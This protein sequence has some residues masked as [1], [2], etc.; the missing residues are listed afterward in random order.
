M[1]VKADTS[2]GFR[3]RIP[4][5]V[6][7]VSPGRQ[8]LR[9]DGKLDDGVLSQ[10]L[11][12]AVLTM[13]RL[14]NVVSSL[15]QEGVLIDFGRA[16]QIFDGSTPTTQSELETLRFAREYQH[17]HETQRSELAPLTTDSICALHGSIYAGQNDEFGPGRLKVA[18]NGV[19]PMPG[20]WTFVA[21]PPERTRQELDA[22]CAWLAAYQYKGEPVSVAAMFF[23][24]FQG[25]HPFHDGN[26]RIGRLLNAHVLKWLGF[27]NIGLVPLDA[28][29]F[30]SGE[31]YYDAIRSTNDGRTWHVWTRYFARQL[32]R[33][34]TDAVHLG[35]L[36]PYL[37][38]LHSQ[39]ARNMALWAIGGDGDWFARRDFPNDGGHSGSGMSKAL[40]TLT[41][42]GF[43]ERRGDKKG[44]EY[45]ISTRFLQ[46]VFRQALAD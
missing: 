34:Y 32:K 9:L 22:L 36:K 29:F 27:Q 14:R 2:D 20:V 33:A 42:D 7:V 8:C 26:G 16:R 10:N 24:E 28:R 12:R 37:D 23:A 35:D 17:I 44:A 30:R 13:A 1:Q 25:I 3:P 38:G 43:L 4:S 6:A 45:R 21:T 5:D 18:Q 40:A 31:R 46:D 19:G 39:S 15:R 11:H 41:S